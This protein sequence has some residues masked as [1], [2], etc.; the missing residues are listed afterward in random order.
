MSNDLAVRFFRVLFWEFIQNLPLVAGF[1][2]GLNFWRQGELGLAIA[3]M[4]AGSVVGSSIIWATESKIVKGHREPLRVVLTNVVVIAVLMLALTAYL[5]AAWSQWWMD[6]VLGMVGGIA[7]CAAQ[8]LA[9]RSPIGWG[10]CVAMALAF[11]LALVGVRAL[12]VAL[13]VLLNT[14]VLAVAV[15]IVIA[16]IDYGSVAVG[17]VREGER[18]P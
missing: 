17:G 6:L 13:P 11:A 1:L 2:S 14:L 12:S 3:C 8:D 7:L 5:A 4:V 15:T 18:T 16:L 10:H 9:A